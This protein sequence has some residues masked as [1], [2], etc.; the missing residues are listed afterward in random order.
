[1]LAK[2]SVDQALIKAKSYTKKGELIEAHKIYQSILK[3]FSKNKR[4][5]H[6]LETLNQIIR[7]IDTKNSRQKVVTELL[8]LYKSGQFFLSIQ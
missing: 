5:Q 1:M 6:G 8:E 3:T 4:A 2:L 7:N